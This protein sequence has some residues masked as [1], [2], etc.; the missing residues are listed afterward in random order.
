MGDN[1]PMRYF[2]LLFFL[3]SL[4]LLPSVEVTSTETITATSMAEFGSPLY[5]EDTAFFPYVNPDAPKGGKIVL[6]DFGTFDSL[7]PYILKGNYP[8]SIGLT[9][10][11]LMSGSG[12][13][14]FAA[15]PLI[16][17]SIEY[18]QDKSWIIFNLNPKARYHDGVTITAEDFVFT[19]E[20]IK[21]HGRP[22]LRSFYAEV[23]KA[24]ALTER[25]LKFTFNSKDSMKPLM[26]VAGLSPLPRHYWQDK[27]ITK[28]TLVPPLASGAYRI[29]TIDP[30]RSITYERVKD[31][32]AQELPVNIGTANIDTI[33]YDYYRDFDIMFVAFTAGKIDFWTEYQSKRWATGYDLPQIQEGT[34]IKEE[35]ADATP[36]GI[37]AFFFNLRQPKFSDIRVREAISLLFDFETTKRTVLFNQYTRTKTFFPN[38]DYGSSGLPTP[39]EIA[40]L[41][42]FKEQLTP[43]V[44]SEPFEPSH[45]EGN[46]RIRK[47]L[48]KAL[49][50][51]KAAGWSLSDNKM[52]NSQGE[53]LVIEFLIDQPSGERII[54]PFIQNM[55]KVG[56]AAS[57]RI[58]DSSQYEN[59]TDNFDFDIIS[60]KLNFFPPPGPEL[61]SYYGSQE[62]DVKGSANLAGIKNPVIDALIEKII[63]AKDLDTLMMT[64][65]AMDRV[66][67]WNHYV[68]PQFHNDIDR[69]AYWNKFSRPKR[70]PKYSVGF[71]STW[72]IDPQKADTLH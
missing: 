70:K 65:R 53:Q 49:R 29:S 21:N 63:A 24:E 11:S 19:L 5:P 61:R 7:N 46:G 4:V 25:R 38:S 69:I 32:W 3:I 62:A 6:G 54:A 39:E 71:P 41:T 72:W 10:D 35:L 2:S 14:L 55:K 67:L 60:V 44:L 37:Q 8:R 16:A 36:Q 23:E 13:E 33:H 34:M 66:L 26:K 51:F 17:E 1:T 56:I 68:I 31:Y 12:D 45:T 58:V 18:P 57:I 9:Q 20:T 52:V 15:Y 42:P 48:R 50:L 27:D 30:G 28:T 40:L 59:R 47:Q 43:A 22:F 64:T